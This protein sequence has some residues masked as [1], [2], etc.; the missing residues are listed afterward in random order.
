MILFLDPVSIYPKLVIVKNN[1]IFKSINILSKNNT[2][3]SDVLLEKYLKL[4]KSFK[5]KNKITKLVV[6]IGPGSYTSL[7]VSISFMYGL[8][9]SMN[10]PLY[11]IS[12]TKLLSHS[13]KK[14]EFYKTF[15]LIFS[16]K[17]QNFICIPSKFKNL[18]YDIKK[19]NDNF[20]NSN[21]DL[22]K[23]DKCIC[24]YK[25]NK[26]IEKQY[27]K[28]KDVIISKIENNVIYED[29]INMKKLKHIEPIYVSENKLFDK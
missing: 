11:G 21:F 2:K 1:K 23:F 9:I 12:C 3:I 22:K 25:P 28:N 17:E 27:L 20:I 15:L 13:I 19:I 10:I 8:S 26:A 7:R 29:F 4:S 14:N 18:V 16:S 5:S 6:C 24:N